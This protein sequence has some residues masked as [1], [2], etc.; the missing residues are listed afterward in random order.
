M[1]TNYRYEYNPRQAAIKDCF[2]DKMD[3][4]DDYVEE[5]NMLMAN[6]RQLEYELKGSAPE[7]VK[8]I[9][10]G[11]VVVSILVG[12]QEYLVVKMGDQKLFGLVDLDGSTIFKTHTFLPDMCYRQEDLNAEFKKTGKTLL[13]KPL[14]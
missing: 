14:D 8:D 7:I 11:D 9:D 1:N 12:A 13:K 10:R 2:G 3:G 5:M 6:I 4:V